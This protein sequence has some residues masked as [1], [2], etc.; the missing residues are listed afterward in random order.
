MALKDS[1]PDKWLYKQHT[2]V[3]HEI[4]SKYLRPWII[5]LGKHHR[6]ICYFDTFAGRGSYKDKEETVPGSPII[7]LR[8][9]DRLLEECKHTSRPPYFDEFVCFLIEKDRRNFQSLE[10]VMEAERAKLKNV[11]ACKVRLINDEFAPVVDRILEN[12]RGDIAPSFFFIDPFGFTGVPFDLVKKVL[13]MKRTEVFFTFMTSFIDRFIKLPNLEDRLNELFGNDE[14]RDLL[15]IDDLHDRDQ[16]LRDLYIKCLKDNGEAKYARDFRVCMDEKYQTLYYLIHATNDFKGLKIMKEIMHNQGPKGMFAYLGPR[17]VY[18]RSQLTLFEQDIGSLKQYLLRRF[19]G[20]TIRFMHI[21]EESYED[22]PVIEPEYRKALKELEK[23]GR[24]NV[25]RF[26]SK[27]E[28]GLSGS[29]SVTF[30][31]VT[32]TAT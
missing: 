28:R 12:L 23:A 16:A 18:Y 5:I 11:D 19:A 2:R 31:E 22:T 4:L 26:S 10:L 21:I 29:D 32:N 27:T 17:D 6:R 24:I 15:R 1:D 30:P 13:S 9:A 7:A 25:A 20:W 14:W 3:K 8:V